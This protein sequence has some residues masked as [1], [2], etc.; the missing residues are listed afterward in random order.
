MFSHSVFHP[1][2][3]LCQSFS[4]P[5]KR[6]KEKNLRFIARSNQQRTLPAQTN[7]APKTL[8]IAPQRRKRITDK[9]PTKSFFQ[10]SKPKKR[11]QRSLF[12][13]KKKNSSSVFLFSK[14]KHFITFPQ[15]KNERF[16]ERNKA[17]VS[18]ATLQVMSQKKKRPNRSQ[19]FALSLSLD[20]PD[21]LPQASYEAKHT[22]T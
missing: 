3:N 19:R 22:T 1:S 8:P 17:F 11:V 2:P 18:N 7:N 14:G 5:S 9:D 16:L 13:V 12:S 15:L 6:N 10:S 21:P 4:K 20:D